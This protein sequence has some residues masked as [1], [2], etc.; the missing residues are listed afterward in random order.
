[1]D[2]VLFRLP[3]KQIEELDSAATAAGGVARAEML[4]Q[5]L[6]IRLAALRRKRK[7]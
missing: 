5:A 4:R 2:A 3:R 1:M 6:E 7:E